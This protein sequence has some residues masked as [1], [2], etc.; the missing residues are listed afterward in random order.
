MLLQRVEHMPK[1]VEEI[2]DRYGTI[3]ELLTWGTAAGFGEKVSTLRLAR[4]GGNSF[5]RNFRKGIDP[6]M[7]PLCVSPSSSTAAPE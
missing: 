5:S 2:R 3:L 7:T 6:Q 4:D 1:V